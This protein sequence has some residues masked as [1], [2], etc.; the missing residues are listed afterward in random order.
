MNKMMVIAA[1][2]LISAAGAV[3][4]TAYFSNEARHKCADLAKVEKRYALCLRSENA[5]VVQSALAHA[6]NMKLMCPAQ[7]FRKLKAEIRD[8]ASSGSTPA[9]RY[10]AYLAGLVFENAAMFSTV[11]QAGYSN[12]EELFMSVASRVQVTYLGEGELTNVSA[13]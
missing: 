6:V 13:R 3:G 10:R 8:L 2:A 9:I 7:E 1:A 12:P 4:Q 5:G 11:R